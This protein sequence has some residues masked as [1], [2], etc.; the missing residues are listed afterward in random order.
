MDGD[1]YDDKYSEKLNEKRPQKVPFSAISIRHVG[2][3]E[4]ANSEACKI[5]HGKRTDN[6]VITTNQIIFTNPI[7]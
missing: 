3:K 5:K 1:R 6:N 2:Q 4:G 7:R